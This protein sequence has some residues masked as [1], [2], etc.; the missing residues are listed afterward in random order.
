[1]AKLFDTDGVL[2]RGVNGTLMTERKSNGNISVSAQ[3][4]ISDGQKAT[5]EDGREI[6]VANT[7]LTWF[8]TISEKTRQR[9]IESMHFAGL[10][11]EAAERVIDLAE[12]GRCGKVPEKFGFGSRDVS[13][14]C[15]IDTYQGKSST[16]IAWVNKPGSR[17]S[18]ADDVE[19]LDLGDIPFAN[20]S[21]ADDSG[22]KN[23]RDS[24]DPF[25]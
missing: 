19:E 20:T 21:D 11:M 13:L 17:K 3:F 23:S 7:T 15:S 1:M 9:T 25:A 10:S 14:N 18:R 5:D 24:D 2:A 8:S 6:S 16:R 22:L 4:K 12:S